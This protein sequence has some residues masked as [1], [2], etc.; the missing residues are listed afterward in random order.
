MITQRFRPLFWV[1]GV[2]VAATALY[3]VSLK[4]AHERARLDEVDLMI[5]QTKRDIRQLQ[6]ELETRSSMRQLER[7]NG[8]ALALSAPHAK[9]FLVNETD[10][11]RVDALSDKSIVTTPAPA[12]ASV[13]VKPKTDAE[14]A[15]EK[16]KA[17]AAVSKPKA[18]QV[19][20][21]DKPA[22]APV[23]SKLATAAVSAVKGH[24][25]P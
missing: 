4:V 19:A 2:A 23:K 6:T 13:A 22:A 5:A 16:A 10:L 14:K 3:T 24:A 9:Q 1:A 25:Q 21:A 7:W 8:E 18:K 12:L 11:S 20:L 17:L 15:A